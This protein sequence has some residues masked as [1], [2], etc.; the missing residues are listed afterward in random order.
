MAKR[1][2]R[3]VDEIVTSEGG[4]VDVTAR[5][6][7]PNTHAADGHSSAASHVIFGGGYDG[8]GKL[9]YCDM[10]QFSTSAIAVDHGDLTEAR[11]LLAAASDGTQVMFGGG[12]SNITI[13]TCDMKQF[14]TDAIAVDHGDLSQVRYGL[15]AGSGN[16]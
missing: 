1:I 11:R 4:V 6:V 14:S 16:A 10:K 15:A 13:N 9:G 2:L 7:F 12:Y 3:N 5:A 8:S